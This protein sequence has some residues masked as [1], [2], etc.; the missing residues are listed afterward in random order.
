M[1]VTINLIE[2]NEVTIQR[3]VI[4]S[5]ELVNTVPNSVTVSQVAIGS[6]DLH[7]EYTQSV[8][9]DQWDVT[10]NLNKKPAVSVFDSNDYVVY[11][12]VHHITN[13]R[14]IIEFKVPIFGRAVF[15]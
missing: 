13:N 11:A 5:V 3:N 8:A 6:G 12:I 15:N 4:G 14:V 9:S 7:F 2:G 10:H 1:S